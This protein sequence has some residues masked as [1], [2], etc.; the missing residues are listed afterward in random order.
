MKKEGTQNNDVNDWINAYGQYL[1]QNGPTTG[2]RSYSEVGMTYSF[3]RGNS[4]FLGL[5][6]YVN[7]EGEHGFFPIVN[8]PVLRRNSFGSRFICIISISYLT[9]LMAI[10]MGTVKRGAIFSISK[11]SS[12]SGSYSTLRNGLNISRGIW[13]LDCKNSGK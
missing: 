11:P 4:V 8:L 2:E 1:P 3:K 6:E 13:S 10:P 12:R 7:S 5:D 9:F